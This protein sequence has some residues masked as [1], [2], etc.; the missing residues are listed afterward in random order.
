MPGDLAD[1]KDVEAKFLQRWVDILVGIWYYKSWY[2]SKKFQVWLTTKFPSAEPYQA[3]SFLDPMPCEAPDFLALATRLAT[4][5]TLETKRLLTRA[6]PPTLDELLPYSSVNHTDFANYL[7]V[8]DYDD[9]LEGYVGSGSN[10]DTGY[11]SRRQLYLRWETVTPSTSALPG[12]LKN[13]REKKHAVE[14][15]G[16]FCLA[17][18]DRLDDKDVLQADSGVLTLLGEY[19]LMVWLRTLPRNSTGQGYEKVMIF[20][21]YNADAMSFVRVNS[22]PPTF[23]EWPAYADLSAT[24][25]ELLAEHKEERYRDMLAKRR[26]KMKNEAE[27]EKLARRANVNV[28]VK[29]RRDRMTEGEKEEKNV[30]DR[31]RYR[32]RVDGWSDERKDDERTKHR[33]Y[34]R[35]QAAME[36]PEERERRS[37]ERRDRYQAQLAAETPAESQARKD[38]K[39][40]ARRI[41]RAEE[42]AEKE[43][44]KK[45]GIEQVD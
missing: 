8:A 43:K 6:L 29:E 18:W 4:G 45:R 21:P 27:D 34:M 41:K 30:R 5:F 19:G 23:L 7:L 40:A 42:R 20:S 14:L 26:E 38:K 33:D 1:D 12:F 2:M 44:A 15:H 37:A 24:E 11:H 39:N 3:P 17:Q 36:T 10:A 35:E 25:L 13:H 16:P 28:A 22:L 32:N 31:Q 9:G